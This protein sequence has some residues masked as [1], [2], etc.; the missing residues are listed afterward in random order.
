MRKLALGAFLVLVVGACASVKPMPIRTGEG[1][2]LCRRPILD[3]RLAAQMIGGRLATNFQAPGCLAAYLVEHPADQ[4]P[5]FV[6][7]FATG[8]M[9]E[10]P[11]AVYVPTVERYTGERDY[12][13]FVDRTAAQTEAAARST[14]PV[15]WDAVLEQA[16]KARPGN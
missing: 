11:A 4:G 8:D 10:A 5:V 7:D 3:R 13:A 1:C 14:S 15:A 12:I 2:F 6:T 9:V 16:R